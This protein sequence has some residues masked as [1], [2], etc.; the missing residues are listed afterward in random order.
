MNAVL[1][2]SCIILSIISDEIH[3]LY[4][5][6]STELYLQINKK[7]ELK[8]NNMSLLKIKLLKLSSVLL[9]VYF[10]LPS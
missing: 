7:T 4:E 3:E 1:E 5:L 2:T 8:S 9:M 10:K 6:E